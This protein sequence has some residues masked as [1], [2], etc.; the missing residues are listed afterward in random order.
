M[1]NFEDEAMIIGN[2]QVNYHTGAGNLLLK[3]IS[4]KEALDL[5]DD[6]ISFTQQ[7]VTIVD[8]ETGY[9]YAKR[10]WVGIPYRSDIFDKAVEEW[11][12]KELIIF[13]KGFY[14]PW[15]IYV[16]E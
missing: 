1:R 11:Y 3:N 4:L 12:E 13:A 16:G 7:D 8:N 5:A 14:K 6:T 2:Y 15:I 9:I 10:E